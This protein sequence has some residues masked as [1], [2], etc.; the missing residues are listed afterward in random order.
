MNMDLQWRG[1]FFIVWEHLK[2]EVQT[3]NSGLLVLQL[4]IAVLAQL[5]ATRGQRCHVQAH[6]GP[7]GQR[8]DV[9]AHAQRVGGQHAQHGPGQ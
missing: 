9:V 6:L 2:R 7:N 8:R 5:G 1:H 3:K 4:G